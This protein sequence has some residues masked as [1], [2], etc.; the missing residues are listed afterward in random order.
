MDVTIVTDSNTYNVTIDRMT[1]LETILEGQGIPCP[2]VCNGEGTCGKCRVKFL[3]DAP[4]PTPAEQKLLGQRLIDRGYRLACEVVIIKDC[5]IYVPDESKVQ[6][7]EVFDTEAIGERAK[8]RREKVVMARSKITDYDA[9]DGV[10]EYAVAI[11]LGTTSIAVELF[12]CLDG[13]VIYATVTE[14]HQSMY[15]VDVESRID[16]S[17]RGRQ[18]DLSA[19]VIRDILSCLEDVSRKLPDGVN[20]EELPIVLAGNTAMIHMLCNMSCAGL[21]DYPYKPQD[22]SEQEIELDDGIF[23]TTFPAISAFIGGDIVSSIY[24]LDI[25]RS[26]EVNVL[27]DLGTNGEMVVNNRGKMLASNIAMGPAFEGGNISCGC[28]S[29]T[30]AIRSV[31]IS[32]GFCKVT[33]IDNAYAIGVC[34]SGVIEAVYEFFKNGIIDEH[35]TF[36]SEFA[37][38]YELC[39]LNKKQSIVF[40]QD[41]VRKM[42]LAKAAIR[43]SIDVLLNEANIS[44]GEI[45]NIYLAGGF[46][47]RTAVDK[48]IGIGALPK[49]WK[50]R[51]IPVGN[52]TLEGARQFIMENDMSRIDRIVN[53]T[54]VVDVSKNDNYQDMYLANVLFEEK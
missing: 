30:G 13:D 29:I 39:Q 6:S 15:G 34:G 7:V 19:I 31:D 24:A 27:I 4:K 46:A 51:V 18:Y 9:L 42:Q 10:C 16:S 38:G 23:V 47:Y 37:L 52:A 1:R 28:A 50:N 41:D 48:L 2:F 22:L 53:N 43:A 44:Y 45:D 32:N 40:L 35:G 5:K 21:A 8:M 17:I 20:I 3:S 54:T 14:N 49:A 11:D 12:D 25:D 36:S 26:D 33:T